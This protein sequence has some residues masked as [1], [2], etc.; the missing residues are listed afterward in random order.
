METELDRMEAKGIIEKVNISDWGTPIVCIPKLNGIVRL[1][2]DYKTMVNPLLKVEQH[3]IPA[4]Q[5]LFLSLSGGEKFSRLD[6]VNVYQQMPLDEASKEMVTIHT[7]WGLYRY[8]RLPYGISSTPAL[9]QQAISTCYHYI[10]K[11]H[12]HMLQA[13]QHLFHSQRKLHGKYI[14]QRQKQ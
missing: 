5:E 12:F 9:F 3:P 4:P 2:G 1:C 13:G 10:I 14:C 8:L 11:I 7:H 6:L